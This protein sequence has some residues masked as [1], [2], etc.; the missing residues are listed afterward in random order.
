MARSGRRWATA[1]FLA[2]LV[3]GGLAGCGEA[4]PTATDLVVKEMSALLPLPNARD[5]SRN[6]GDLG[7]EEMITTDGVTV[8]SW[9]DPA[10]ASAFATAFGGEGVAAGPYALTFHPDEYPYS[11]EAHD[12][13]VAKA[14][15]I[16][17]R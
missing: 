13:W 16:A 10:D 5:N 7:C 4:A 17:S 11:Q 1:G 14:R 2:A 8:T 9:S 6:C 12:A 15:E 3:A